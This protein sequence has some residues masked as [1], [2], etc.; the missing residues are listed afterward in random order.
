MDRPIPL[1][2]RGRYR[3]GAGAS[4][5]LA[6]FIGFLTFAP[7]ASAHHPE[8]SA[9]VACETEGAGFIVDFESV[10]WQTNGG[11]TGGGANPHIDISYRLRTDGGSASAWTTL[12]WQPAYRYTSANNYRFTDTIDLADLSGGNQIQVRATATADWGNGSDGGQTTDTAWQTLPTNCQPPG[13]PTVGSSVACTNGNG[14]VVVTLANSAVAGAASVSF[15]VT[16]PRTNAATTRTLAAGQSDSVTLT[17]FSDGAVTIPVTADGIHHDQT[18]TVACDRP[19]LPAVSAQVACANGNGDVTVSL[20]NTGG[21]LP[22]TFVV[23]DPRTNATTTRT[24]APGESDTVM[25]AGFADGAVT[26]P[27]TANG[28]AYDQTVTVACDRRGVASVETTNACINGDGDISV[29]LANTGGD[30]PVTFVVTDPRTGA[31]TTRILA[32]GQSDTVTLSG[33]ADGVVT[34]PVTTNG[35]KADQT[36]TVQ[37][38]IPGTP[39]VSAG[40][41]C[42]SGNGDLTVTLANTAGNQPIEFRVTDPRTNAVTDRTV[43]PGASTTV[44]L[45]GF[46][47]GTVTI[48]VTADGAAL[49]QTLTIACD[50]PGVPAVSATSACVD[51]DGDV[52]VALA[53]VGGTEPIVFVVSDPRDGTTTTRSIAVG[54]SA[55]V[56]LAGFPDGTYTIG[57]TA[58]GAPLDEI[59]DVDCDRPGLPAVFSDVECAAPGGEVLVT[60]GN[61][62]AVGQA[63]SITFSVTDPRDPSIVTLLTLAPGE[64]GVVTVDSLADGSYVIPV[65]ADD[66]ALAPIAVTVDCQQPEVDAISMDCGNGGQ[67]VTVANPGGTPATVTVLKDGVVVDDL[68][69][70]AEGE[71][72]VLVTMSEDE[73]ATITVVDGTTEL[74]NRTVTQDC[75]D[76][77]TTTTTV[78][79]D[80]STTTTVPGEVT[81]TVAGDPPAQVLSDGLTRDPVVQSATLP[82]TGANTLG[83]VLFGAALVVFGFCAVQ[84]QRRRS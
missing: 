44:I 46:P 80:P 35:A 68:L 69:V 66:V 79:G 56:T 26:L 23:T 62:S 59:V 48:P 74:V 7:G 17:G 11:N 12:T 50:V 43:A 15:V 71:A 3:V 65:S 81:T 8:I 18:L 38:D 47:D 29:A 77:I 14:D 78:P 6:L 33:F 16:D 39:Q 42:A 75:E 10:S 13:S 72:E 58:D 76:E 19:G 70:P 27:V 25:L 49:D 84:A 5:V 9:S 41:V 21:D 61:S 31:S 73:T 83:L 4:L 45:V 40:S 82:V 1:T 57:I 63:E 67:V 36:V 24:L 34:I 64:T 28:V 51:F 22:V 30:L 55:T 2:P 53:N 60:V 52:V 20:A 32:P 54:D 37:C